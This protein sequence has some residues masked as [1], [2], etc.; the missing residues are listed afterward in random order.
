MNQTGKGSEEVEQD[1]D[2]SGMGVV[3][4]I[5]DTASR[6]NGSHVGETFPASNK[7]ILRMV[8]TS[9][10]KRGNGPVVD[11][12]GSFVV[13]VFTHERSSVFGQALAELGVIRVGTLGRPKE[14]GVVEG[15]GGRRFRRKGVG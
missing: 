15:G 2:R 11:G 9:N 10:Q 3:A 1:E 13:G 8:G 4:E 12:N 7:A 14:E 6:V 5:Q